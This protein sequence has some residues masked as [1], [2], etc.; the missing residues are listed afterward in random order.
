MAQNQALGLL[1]VAVAALLY[2]SVAQVWTRTRSDPHWILP[3]D[4][5]AMFGVVGAQVLNA[6]VMSGAALLGTGALSFGLTLL[7][8]V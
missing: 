1:L 6:A 8:S 7:H 2:F 5:R 4:F 3:G